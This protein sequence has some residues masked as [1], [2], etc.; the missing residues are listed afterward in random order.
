MPALPTLYEAGEQ[1]EN[2]NIGMKMFVTIECSKVQKINL[3]EGEHKILEMANKSR[4]MTILSLRTS[5][6]EMIFHGKMKGGE[7]R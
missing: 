1:I 7:I 3:T 2:N 4:R 5:L 6:G